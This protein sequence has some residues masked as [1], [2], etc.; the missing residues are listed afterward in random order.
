MKR[1]LILTVVSIGMAVAAKTPIAVTDGCSPQN[2]AGCKPA[3]QPI[4]LI[5]D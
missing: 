4:I 5:V 2:P 1:I 3:E